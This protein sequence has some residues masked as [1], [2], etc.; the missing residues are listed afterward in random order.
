MC[1]VAGRTERLSCSTRPGGPRG[2]AAIETWPE[3]DAIV[4]GRG[5]VLEAA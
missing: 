4:K 1:I 5:Q 2:D 3:W